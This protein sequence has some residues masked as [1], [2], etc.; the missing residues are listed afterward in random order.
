MAVLQL[1]YAPHP[2][3][4]QKSE[5]VKVVDDEIRTIVSNMFDTL[6]F[7]SAAGIGAPMVGILK[8]IAVVDVKPNGV[9][10]PYCFINPKIIATSHDTQTIEEA[11]LC[12]P[13]ISAPITRP[14]TITVEY[15]DQHGIQQTLEASDFLSSVIQHELDYL[16]GKVYLDYLSPMKRNMLLKKMQ[17]QL[18]LHPPHIH[19]D[20]CNH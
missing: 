1:I 7:E 6:Y 11:S 15:L 14:K 13:F 9:D 17:K 18:K 16:D 8:R 19:G 2:I 3:F 4:K 20:H 5:A 10:T 12:F